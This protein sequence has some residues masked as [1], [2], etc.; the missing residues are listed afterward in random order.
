MQSVELDKIDSESE[1][2]V[3]EN[4]LAKHTRTKSYVRMAQ[5]DDDRDSNESEEVQ[6]SNGASEAPLMDNQ[7]RSLSP[8][9][10]LNSIYDDVISDEEL[11]EKKRQTEAIPTA[12]AELQKTQQTKNKN[13]T[14]PHQTNSTLNTEAEA[15]GEPNTEQ[16][17]ELTTAEEPSKEHH[18]KIMDKL[19]AQGSVLDT[20]MGHSERLDG[21]WKFID[22]RILLQV[23]ITG[24][25]ALSTYYIQFGIWRLFHISH[26]PSD[27][28]YLSW[29]SLKSS[30]YDMWQHGFC[31]IAADIYLLTATIID[32]DA[33][34]EE[35]ILNIPIR[36][37]R[38]H[39][40]AATM[41]MAF[42]VSFFISHYNVL[43]HTLRIPLFCG[44]CVIFYYG[45]LIKYRKLVTKQSWYILW[46]LASYVAV[47]VV[48]Y[49]LGVFV[50]WLF[51]G[52]K[53]LG[54]A[55]VYPIYIGI[56]QTI[57]LMA[58]R[59]YHHFLCCI[60]KEKYEERKDYDP[61]SYYEPQVIT[62]RYICTDDGGKVECDEAD[63]IQ[64]VVDGRAVEYLWVDEWIYYICGCMIVFTESMRISG[65]LVVKEDAAGIIV[66]CVSAL[67]MEVL[68][69]NN[70]VWE[71]LYGKVLKK[72]N[73]DRS[74]FDAIYYGA[75]F[76]WEY[77][78]IGLLI[79]MNFLQF[80]PSNP[81]V[82]C[83]KKSLNNVYDLRG[84]YEW[85]AIA[86]LLFEMLT[87]LACEFTN[88]ILRKYKVIPRDPKQDG[89]RKVILIRLGIYGW[90]AVF[91]S[92]I[93]IAQVGYA[94]D[95]AL[96]NMLN[97]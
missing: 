57:G 72:K 1:I 97:H 46:P 87:D 5:T 66:S 39:L 51:R 36:K 2:A 21:L 76:S 55:A 91:I 37:L 3:S 32:F 49:S 41:C 74:K 48:V 13:N 63:E 28:V 42:I 45:L 50:A 84:G 16:K 8:Q 69:R 30:V 29:N 67:V 61:N 68:Q 80:G 71:L 17:I 52:N 78:P 79:Q 26:C 77:L 92:A 27:M 9:D 10:I 20:S 59:Y 70:L 12:D 82:D 35:H 47:I 40:V 58:M 93:Q 4:N 23:A 88:W 15:S 64:E 22:L 60:C 96:Y 95:Y 94:V 83:Y 54:F 53:G 89:A 43:T 33:A 11:S 81:G 18:I 7:Q 75:K 31:I 90:A 38:R 34:A 6:T 24:I 73:P 25:I 44:F 62:A 85:I 14:K 65:L 86:I 56:A 19:H